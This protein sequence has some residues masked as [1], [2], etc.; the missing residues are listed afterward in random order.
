ME[1]LEDK[2]LLDLRDQ[3]ADIPLKTKIKFFRETKNMSRKELSDKT[4]ISV[5][6]IQKYELGVRTPKLETL[7]AITDALELPVMLFFSED[8]WDNAYPDIKED[9]D[10][11]KAFK[12]IITCMG[13]DIEEY[14]RFEKM[15]KDDFKDAYEKMNGDEKKYYDDI[16]NKQGYIEGESFYYLIYNKSEKYYVTER[17]FLS[18][19]KDIENSII[20]SFKKHNIKKDL[21]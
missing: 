13:Y 12:N 2:V 1:N 5:S 6:A 16:L 20:K 11:I 15:T 14:S 10:R 3:I 9:V 17:A 18:I 21:E 19:Q 8:Y 4:G 7:K